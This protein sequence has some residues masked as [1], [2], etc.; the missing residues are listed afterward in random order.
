MFDGLTRKFSSLIDKLSGYGVL[1]EANIESA[2]RD[3]RLALLEAD[4]HVSVVRELI[5]KIK[6]RVLGQEV[7]RSL[8]PHQE[9]LRI[10]HEELVI[11]LGG[12]PKNLALQGK[13]PQVILLAGLQ[14]SG[15][16]T[17]AGKL[18]LLLKKKGRKPYLVPADVARPA[19]IEQ[20]Q[21]LAGKLGLPCFPTKPGDNPVKVAQKGVEAAEEA[22]CDVV[23][24]DTAGRLAIDAP[25]M[26]ELGKLHKKLDQPTV[27]Y[28]ADAM[29]GQEACKVAKAFHDLLKLD[30][31]ILT[32]LDGDAR[33]GAA[34]SIQTVVGAPIYF[35]GVGEKPEDFEVFD[36]GRLVNRLLDRGDILSL[37]EKAREVV[38]AET[39][40]KQQK[41]FLKNQ[42]TMEDLR[43]QFR[44][45][46]KMGSLQNIVGM[47]PGGKAMSQKINMDDAARDVKKKEAIID[48]MTKTERANPDVLNGSR[49]LRIA[50]GSGTQVSDVNRLVK[51]FEMMKKMMKQ[52]NKG[53]MGALKGMFR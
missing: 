25:L 13:T 1:T 14:G 12:A 42:F 17:T 50:K 30:G 27:L 5:E 28:V 16:T 32:K 15:K 53:G 3:V 48:S 45:M 37:V 39:A 6:P 19:A 7:S 22:F 35:A 11:I 29:M 43:T 38:D 21:S 49:R 8:N 51:E 24:V 44:Q 47:L 9:F 2:V 52:F 23:I 34:L 26:E 46:K 4:V 31:L 40:A 36:P 41:R 10:F 20:L 18:A 33:G